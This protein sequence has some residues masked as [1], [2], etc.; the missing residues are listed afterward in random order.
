MKNQID[1]SFD[2]VSKGFQIWHDRPQSLKTLFVDIL[3]G[4][5][6]RS[7]KTSF[8]VLNDLSFQIH[9]GDFIGIMGRNGAGKSTI[10]K[11]MC[12]IYSPDKGKIV[13]SRRIA[14][15]IELGAGFSGDLS[16]YE[17]I[18][19]N[20][21]ILGY[22]RTAALRAV[23]QIIEFSEL[24]DKINMPVKNY[25]SGMLVRLGF[26]IATH[27][28]TEILL[29]DEILAVGDAGFQEKCVSKIIELNRQGTTV[30]LITHNPEHVKKF[31]DRCIVINGH[32][33]IFDGTG[34]EGSEVYSQLFDGKALTQ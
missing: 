10:L 23:D 7:F 5:F 22:G 15:L 18:L 21:A 28:P 13:A 26:S 9:A 16:G 20:A 1:I 2:S 11:L 33:K 27:L 19:L 4:N 12:G 17:N 8:Q 32:E 31:C 6:N 30:V 34:Q 25:S 3:K 29:I 14:P 24:A